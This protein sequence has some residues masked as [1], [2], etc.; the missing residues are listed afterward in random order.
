MNVGTACTAEEDRPWL[1]LRREP[2]EHGLLPLPSLMHLDGIDSLRSR[3][4][5][6][7]ANHGR[8]RVETSDIAAALSLPETQ[9][10]L[11]L[12]TLASVLP[13]DGI[14]ADPL[15]RA[16][17]DSIDSVGA[18]IDDLIIFLYIQ[19]YRKLVPRP[20][21]D[22][23][24]VGEIW[25]STSAFDR[26]LPSLSPLQ[27]RLARR[28]VPFQA[29]EEVHQLT[30]VQKHLPSMLGLLAELT[31]DEDS[32]TK[33]VPAEKFEHL[34]LLFQVHDSSGNIIHLNQ[35]AP[36]FANS[37]PDMPAAPVPLYQVLDWM[38]EHICAASEHT[39]EKGSTKDN[40]PLYNTGQDVDITM[41]DASCTTTGPT[42]ITSNGVS[43]P[44]RDWS[45]ESVTYVDAVTRTS[46]LKGDA[47][48]KGT[49]LKVSNCHDTAIYVLAPFKYASVVGCSDSIIILGPVGKALRVEH[50]ERVQL[51][52]P[53]A[54]ISIANC[55][56]CV[57]YLGVSQ[58][59]LILGDN[60]K[61]QVAPY[62]TFYPRLETHLA[63]AG[64]NPA[65]N[66]WDKILTLGVVD[67]HDSL[68]HPAGVA[69]AQAE[70][71]TFVHPDRYTS[72]MV[73]VPGL[74]EEEQD[75]PL[76]MSNPFPLPKAYLLAQ[77]QRVPA[78]ENLRQ[79]LKDA[80]LNESN[81]RELSNAI[82]AHFKEW[83][84]ASGNVRQLYDIQIS[85]RDVRNMD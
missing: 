16:P 46:V 35:A 37:D 48:V 78:M 31:N 50:C 47:D 22:A 39:F 19:N 55:R 56:E 66:R 30:W 43:Q 85:D 18:N 29:E 69:D 49:S 68:S 13:D 34:G 84:Y 36:F 12:D 72:F 44:N 21:R 79:M 74:S 17:I 25:P 60:H 6:H 24:A 28:S 73:C 20:Y 11:V 9:A 42:G 67:P 77:Q 76:T 15:A 61:L 8:Q 80:P 81:K 45:P 65:V 3:L 33:V 2:F 59:P 1:H 71:A 64:L 57:F 62:N 26:F 75:Q 27:M 32:E 4:L 7:A 83:I 40:G 58:Q 5:S 52:V 82:H 63:V 38:L 70:G 23:A 53:C 41:V 14:H 10:H 51:V 54:R